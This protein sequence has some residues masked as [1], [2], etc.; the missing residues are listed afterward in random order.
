LASG[1][2]DEPKIFEQLKAGEMSTWL[3]IMSFALAATVLTMTPGPDTALVIRTAVA[4]GPRPAWR[5]A[6]GVALGCLIWGLLASFGLSGLILASPQAFLALK[7]AGACYLIWLG[8]KLLHSAKNSLASDMPRAG[9]TPFAWGLMT[10]LLNPKVGLFYLSFLPQF[11]PANAN[12]FWL[13]VA[14]TA[15]H[16]TLGLA[17]FF[18]LISFTEKFAGGMSRVL[19]KVVG[20]L[21]ISLGSYLILDKA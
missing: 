5:A 15:A 14:M 21:F 1:C 9:D 20:G 7:L 8:F 16:A 17:W 13:T 19:D 18:I 2:F 4:D 3:S 10:N 11:V 6:L 12:V